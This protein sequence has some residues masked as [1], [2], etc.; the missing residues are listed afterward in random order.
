[1]QSLN[2]FVFILN[3]LGIHWIIYHQE[4]T[5]E[6]I[7]AILDN[8]LCTCNSKIHPIQMALIYGIYTLFAYAMIQYIV[9]YLNVLTIFIEIWIGKKKII[10]ICWIICNSYIL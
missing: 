5:N 6:A 7:L 10:T 4:H 3:D 8:I 1:M 9:P 2:N